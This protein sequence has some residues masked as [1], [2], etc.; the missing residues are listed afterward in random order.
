MADLSFISLKLVL[1]P[2]EALL[3]KNFFEGILLIKPQFEVGK[4]Y[5]SKGGVVRNSKY[6]LLALESVLEAVI[7]I[8][9]NINGLIAS[10][11]VGPAGNHEYLLWFSKSKL[12]DFDPSNKFLNELIMQTLN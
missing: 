5:V 8:K 7:D 10:P 12:R 6:H 3:N 4:K 9:W 2:I 1:K 11:L